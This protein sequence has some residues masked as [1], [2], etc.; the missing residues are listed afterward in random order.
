MAGLRLEEGI[1]LDSLIEVA[2]GKDLSQ[3]LDMSAVENLLKYGLIEMTEESLRVT[4]K[5]RLTLDS[6]LL[7]LLRQ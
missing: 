2:G 7:H 4:S 1:R 3:I 6:V 5:G